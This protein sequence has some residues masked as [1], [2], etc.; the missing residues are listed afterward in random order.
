MIK[1]IKKQAAAL[2]ALA[3]MTSSA[4]IS[5][6]AA[7]APTF[8]VSDAK[9]AQGEEVTVNI[10]CSG[11]TALTAWKVDVTYDET[12]LDLVK[13]DLNGAF[14]GVSDGNPENVP[15]I[16]SWCDALKNVDSNGKMA[17]L[18]FK[19]KDNAKVG[20][21]PITLNYQENEVFKLNDK[22]KTKFDTVHFD[23]K[24]GKVTVTA[25]PEPKPEPEP[26][27]SSTTESKVESK[28][29]SKTESK[30]ESKTDSKTESKSTESKAAGSKT[31]SSKTT[32]AQN[33]SSS[34]GSAVSS[35]KTGNT[36]PF[37]AT[38][39]VFTGSMAIIASCVGKRKD[40]D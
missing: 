33:T 40:N 7:N 37:I 19:I 32:S 18:T 4:M 22:D 26:I 9:G 29:E 10:E 2:I 34:S 24:N 39:L 35:P 20:D 16:F 13:S 5:A 12:A 28:T 25:K 36:S 21:Y 15:Y 8:T 23:V 17:E 31:T 27:T 30:V 38:L 1:K 3:V 11:N 14:A 6:F